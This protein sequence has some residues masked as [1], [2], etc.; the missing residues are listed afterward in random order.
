MDSSCKRVPIDFRDGFVLRFATK[1]DAERL[2]AFHHAIFDA[3]YAADG[4]EFD[5]IGGWVRH[6][7]SGKHPT[8]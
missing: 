1:G 2:A 3:D 5:I 6:L 4:A 8:F 7:V